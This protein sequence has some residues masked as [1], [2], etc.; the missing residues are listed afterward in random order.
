MKVLWT[1]IV[2]PT[3]ATRLAIYLMLFII[4]ASATF[5]IVQYPSLPWLLSVRFK[6]DGAPVGWQ[7]RTPAR[8]MMPVFVQLALLSTFG[9]ISALL[10][11]RRQGA[12]D[13]QA[14]DVKAAAAAAEAV[15]L[16]ALI[17]VSV[18]GYAAWALV[19]MWTA[20]R[21]GLG[22][23]TLVELLGLVATGVVAVR[24]RERLGRPTPRPYVAEHWRFG[25][26]YKNPDDPALFVPTR[27]GSRWTLNFG[28]PV[29]AALLG[30]ILIIGIVG[31]TII[32]GI[33]LRA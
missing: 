15:T 11:S 5:L 22:W 13:A 16:I 4:V 33:A 24:A 20:E 19:R 29:A 21:A 28:R 2:P 14:P 18:Q 6:A 32:L 25:Q 12:D 7:Y 3:R 1:S 9:M 8:V 17:W 31:P 27:D 30:V 23:Y 26:L 10:L